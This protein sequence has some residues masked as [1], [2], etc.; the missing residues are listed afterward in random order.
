MIRHIS[1]QYKKLAAIH[2]KETKKILH[3][4]MI[5]NTHTQDEREISHKTLTTS[6]EK[7]GNMFRIEH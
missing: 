2:N 4:S 7:C 1:Q 3:H 5:R 6:H